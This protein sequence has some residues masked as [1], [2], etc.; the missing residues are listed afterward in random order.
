MRSLTTEIEQYTQR[1][2]MASNILL[3]HWIGLGL[4]AYSP[5]LIAQSSLRFFTVSTFCE[6]FL[7]KETI[8]NYFY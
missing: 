5:I 8:V 4:A 1:Q 7:L 3:K 6:L 2:F